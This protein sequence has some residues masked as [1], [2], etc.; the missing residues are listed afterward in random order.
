MTTKVIVCFDKS[1]ANEVRAFQRRLDAQHVEKGGNPDD[2]EVKIIY[3]CDVSEEQTYMSW[4]GTDPTP[5]DKKVLESLTSEDKIYIWGHGAPNYAY[6]SGSIYTEL[7]DYLEKGLNKSNFGDNHAPLEIAVEICN[8]G[9]G[10][11]IGKDSYAARLHALM[12][13]KGIDCRVSARMRNV[14][15]DTS[16]LEYDGVR[17]I[18][19]YQDGLEQAGIY[20]SDQWHQR[21]ATGSKVVYEWEGVNLDIQVRTDGYRKS[22]LE[23]FVP[24]KEA[25]L[26]EANTKNRPELQGELRKVCLAIEFHLART[27]KEHSRRAV[28]AGMQELEDLCQKMGISTEKM[29]EMGVGDFKS[30]VQ[31]DRV[32]NGLIRQETGVLKT[33]PLLSIER[34]EMLNFIHND[35]SFVELN[36]LVE[37]LKVSEH[38]SSDALVELIGC[39]ETCDTFD[40]YACFLLVARS[41]NIVNNDGELVI[42]SEVQK[43]MAT[44]NNMLK[45]TYESDLPIAQKKQ[46]LR[47]FKKELV[48]TKHVA[49]A[50]DFNRPSESS[51]YQNNHLYFERSEEGMIHY[52]LQS[53]DEIIEGTFEIGQLSNLSTK[54]RASL[55]QG[56]LSV[57][58]SIKK[59][60]LDITFKQGST[61]KELTFWG[62]I[63]VIFKAI[64][65]SIS[66]VLAER[67]D[68]PLIETIGNLFHNT[69]LLVTT[70]LSDQTEYASSISRVCS[71]CE[72]ELL[73]QENIASMPEKNEAEVIES[74]SSMPS[75]IEKQQSLRDTI[76]A[77]KEQSENEVKVDEDYD[78]YS[79]LSTIFN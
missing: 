74:N 15:I 43:S 40:M 42:P 71:I 64:H 22:T 39:K 54:D 19:R 52:S 69:K 10:G 7:A 77:K 24:L 53:E 79:T 4:S 61:Q 12:G 48:G 32:Q 18:K 78:A 2:L 72:G 36:R 30:L 25:L 51:D 49:Y 21:K 73:T 34:Q 33:D 70:Q 56:D 68:A 28:N 17:T 55:E 59:D 45:V 44:L 20:K 65:E 41:Y 13:K 76:R 67:H 1:E 38:A 27:D 26:A 8:G 75:I 16:T 57:L 14:S 58:D 29:D 9:R 46:Q 35:P 11:E 60:V 5:E 23:K 66:S 3:P 37:N 62:K 31:S 6:I 50:F 47:Q 63:N